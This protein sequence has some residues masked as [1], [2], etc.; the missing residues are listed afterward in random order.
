MKEHLS[1]RKKPCRENG[2]TLIEVMIAIMI[3]SV[4]LLSVGV[5][6][7][8]AMKG[9]ATSRSIGGGANKAAEK[10]EELRTLP[11]THALVQER[12]DDRDGKAGLGDAGIGTSDHS[13]TIGQYK[14]FWNVADA[15]VDNNTRTVAVIV[16]WGE[17]KTP[18]SVVMQG[19]IPK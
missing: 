12:N 17:G 9:N 4:G 7:T 14:I 15:M 11:V 19:V 1:G 3:L 2:F 8:A 13:E 10:L 18:H 5:M 16:Q 6:Q